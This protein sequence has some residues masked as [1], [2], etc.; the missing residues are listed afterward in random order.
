VREPNALIMAVTVPTE[1]EWQLHHQEKGDLTK[2]ICLLEEFPDVWAEKRPP[3]LA[4]NHALIMVD[5]KTG[6]LPVRQRKYPVPQ[7]ACL[8]SQAHLQQLKDVGI[9]IKC[10]LPWNTPLLPV[11]KAGGND[12]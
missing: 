5:L 10:L 11:K 9:L 2:P 1:D 6:A 3:G 4:L 12:H 7:E 8:E